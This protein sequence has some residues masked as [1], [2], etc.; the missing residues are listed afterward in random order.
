MQRR[1]HGDALRHPRYWF[2]LAGVTC[3]YVVAAKFGINL[4]VAHG[5]ITPVWAPS[6]IALAALL[7]FG[8]RLWPAVFL[9]AL[10]AN[11]TS[12]AELLV[13]AGIAVGNTLEA[14]AGAFFLRKVGFRNDLERV[15][16][17]LALVVLAAG[18][19]TL[20]SA[21]NG[22][23]VLSL[24]LDTDGP[25]ASDWLLWW[26][27]DAV[28]ILMVAPL[29]LVAWSHRTIRLRMP[30]ILEA[31]VLLCLLIAVSAIVF[32]AGAWRYPYL[33]F[34]F[35]LWA[36]LRFRLLG[37]ATGSFVV[38]A[39][40]TWGTMAGN[41][42]IGA[43][44]STAR[45]QIIQAL[46]GVV[47]ISLLVLGATLAERETANEA[48]RQTTARLSEAQA[49]THIGSWEWNI[50]TDGVTWSDE[51]YRIFGFAPQSTPVSPD[52]FLDHVHPDDRARI[53]ETVACAFA[54]RRPFSFEHRIALADGSERLLR[55]R[56][57]A[58]ADESGAPRRMVGT[59]QDITEQ[60]HA[61]NLRDDVLS[62]VS[63]ELRGPLGAVLGYSSILQERTPDLD[64]EA[65]SSLVEKI[66]RQAR[67]LDR[68]LAD[69]LDADRLR[70]GL[71]VPTREPTDVT[72]L[73]GQIATAHRV[74]EH[75]IAVSAEPI[76]ANIDAQKV[77]RIVDNLLLNAVKHTP[78]GTPIALR[79]EQRGEDLLI[80]VND[81]GPG[82]P[83]EV[84]S[85]V[86]EIFDRG[87][88]ATPREPGTGIGLSLVARFAAI[89]GGRAWVEDSDSGGA[90]FRVLLPDCVLARPHAMGAVGLADSIAT[91][92]AVEK[93]D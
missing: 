15:R 63:H 16:D 24:A 6:G 5:V 4:S 42:A 30:Q 88:R 86:F 50:A 44:D 52:F 37:A 61:E 20:I 27:G 3:A 13:A 21:T 79:L 12:E 22:V 68:I 10:I 19:S 34:P 2:L 90:S 14:V 33:I 80:V 77:E 67:R 9:G 72:D 91:M 71:V 85:A 31:L 82:I 49:L 35:L 89:H 41:V 51:L 36:V 28:G 18:L 54:D 78:P 25:Y 53:V 7:I 87:P 26:F 58:I 69:L 70:H 8:P 74:T 65:V 66:I 11:W 64:E 62:T 60:K 56:G 76:T 17:V 75:A 59:A 57:S 32:L 45:V 84:K 43:T 1:G 55:G 73:V 81:D 93:P 39:I 48:L 29:L 92:A 46:V 38:G 40:A 83:D 23:I 47:A